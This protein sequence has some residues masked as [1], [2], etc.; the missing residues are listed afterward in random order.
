MIVAR[1]NGPHLSDPTWYRVRYALAVQCLQLA[2]LRT[3]SDEDEVGWPDGMAKGPGEW[4]KAYGLETASL[5]SSLYTDR[6]SADSHLIDSAEATMKEAADLV[7]SAAHVL[8]WAGWRWV[9]REPPAYV[10]HLNVLSLPGIRP[11]NPGRDLELARFLSRVVEPAAVILLFS[12][13]ALEAVADGDQARLPNLDFF[14][15]EEIRDTLAPSHSPLPPPVDRCARADRGSGWLLDYLAGLSADWQL[16]TGYP[17]HSRGFLGRRLLGAP[18]PVS[19]RVLYDLA[20]LFSRLALVARRRKDD[21]T[22][23]SFLSIAGAQ[24]EKVLFDTPDHQRTDFLALA[25]ADPGLA[26]LRMLREKEFARIVTRWGPVNQYSVDLFLDDSTIFRY[27]RASQAMDV[28][29]A[30]GSS[31]RYLE[32]SPDIF[33]ALSHAEEPRDYFNQKIQGIHPRIPL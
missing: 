26:G 25:Q 16:E 1:G 33:E 21:R 28:E 12:A 29:F 24:L 15:Y 22:E 17:R 6:A 23:H 32:I 11:F 20:C 19:F 9:G 4:R 18:R 10:R 5:L 30:D 27:Y 14:T 8:E 7:A 13:W 3:Q 31:Y 2:T